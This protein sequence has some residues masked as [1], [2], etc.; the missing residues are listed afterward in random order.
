MSVPAIKT[1]YRED[2]A[3]FPYFETNNFEGWFCQ[4]RKFAES[5]RICHGFRSNPRSCRCTWEPIPPTHPS[6]KTFRSGSRA[7]RL[8]ADGIQ[9]RRLRSSR[10]PRIQ[11]Y[12]SA[13]PKLIAIFCGRTPSMQQLWTLPTIPCMTIGQV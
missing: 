5:T 8:R 11:R 12:R 1:I 3:A 4:F 6:S 9:Q 10:A 2:P 7:N 13:R